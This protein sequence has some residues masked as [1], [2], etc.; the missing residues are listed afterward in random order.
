MRLNLEFDY[1]KEKTKSDYAAS[2]QA[3][4]V[5]ME[6]QDVLKNEEQQ[7]LW[8][9]LET[10]DGREVQCLVL[11][12]FWVDDVQYIALSPE[13]EENALLFRF[14]ILSE[15]DIN[16][17]DITDEDEFEAVSSAFY[18]LMDEENQM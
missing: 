18:K 12:V 16:I 5:S 1:G 6:Y 4:T 15:Q 2:V 10:V 7:A 14:A 11:A 9:P 17:E 3:N 8:I 13:G